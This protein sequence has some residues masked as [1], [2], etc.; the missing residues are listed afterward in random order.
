LEEFQPNIDGVLRQYEWNIPN[1]EGIFYHD[2]E[3]CRMGGFVVCYAATIP[4]T[5]SV[6]IVTTYRQEDSY[7]H[8]AAPIIVADVKYARLCM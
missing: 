2:T 1:T 6:N 4:S 8:I 7:I 5:L 3:H